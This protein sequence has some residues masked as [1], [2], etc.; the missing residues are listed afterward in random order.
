MN[1][2]WPH[3]V[4]SEGTCERRWDRR[5]VG[6]SWVHQFSWKITSSILVTEGKLYVRTS[7]W[8]ADFPYW[9]QLASAVASGRR[10]LFS[11]LTETEHKHPETRVRRRIIV[12]LYL[13][14]G[15]WHCPEDP[16]FS[17]CSQTQSEPFQQNSMGLNKQFL[18]NRALVTCT[19][20]TP[21]IRLCKSHFP[22]KEM[23]SFGQIWF[24]AAPRGLAV[25]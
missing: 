4:L 21:Q 25:R 24:S 10:A 23:S 12:I 7:S 15:I 8:G 19:K 20:A 11:T 3:H 16:Y 6:R 13:K 9:E 18:P 5:E 14:Q 22:M 2:V 17:V 1:L